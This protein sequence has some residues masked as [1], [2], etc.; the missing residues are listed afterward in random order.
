MDE[1]VRELRERQA[2]A[3]EWIAASL[4]RLADVA[5][6]VHGKPAIGSDG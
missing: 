5:E 6:H 1:D 3:L 2:A 4:E